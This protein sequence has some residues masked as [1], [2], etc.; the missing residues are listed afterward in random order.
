MKNPNNCKN[1]SHKETKVMPRDKDL[2]CYM[3]K[4]APTTKCGVFSPFV[5]VSNIFS[6][7]LKT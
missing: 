2:H 1:C 3:F 6:K 7:F 5:R 4:D